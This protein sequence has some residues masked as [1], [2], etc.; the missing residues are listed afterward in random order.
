M[1][2]PVSYSSDR[3]FNASPEVIASGIEQVLTAFGWKHERVSPLAF[4]G[5]IGISI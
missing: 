3:K 4:K 5:H 1:S 2:I